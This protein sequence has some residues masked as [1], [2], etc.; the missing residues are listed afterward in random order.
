L[1]ISEI[2]GLDFA[3]DGNLLAMGGSFREVR[4]FDLRASEVVRAF[5]GDPQSGK[6]IR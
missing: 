1:D 3:P 6:K 2:F 4:I 5:P